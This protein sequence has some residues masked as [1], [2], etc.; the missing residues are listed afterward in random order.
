MSNL[1]ELIDSAELIITDEGRVYH[2]DLLPEELADTIL[3]VG[4]PARVDL[5]AEY[6]DNVE[7]RRSHREFCTITGSYRNQRL[8]VI[9][10]GIGTDN[11][12]IVVNEL[13][14]LVNIDFATRQRR[15]KTRSLQLIRMGTCGAL[16]KQVQ[17][18]SLIFSDW[19]LGL[20][21]LIY[22]YADYARVLD[23][24]L[25]AKLLSS[26]EWQIPQI[27]P[28]LVQCSADLRA[29]FSS[30]KFLHGLTLT[31]PGFYG[32]QVRELRLASRLKSFE[33]RDFCHNLS[34]FPPILNFE[35]EISALYAL[36]GLLEHKAGAVCVAVA[37]RYAGTFVKN[38]ELAVR[39][40][41]ESVLTNLVAED[42]K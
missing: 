34:E 28:Y 17:A 35:M 40:L 24:E 26:L 32:P 36:A 33:Q 4:D 25:N 23:S 5:V 15:E 22:Y 31:A 38:S 11:I 9:S 21:N 10:T 42:R 13:D 6:W 1:L 7:F 39:N 27:S 19:A 37:N 29:V 41:I 8:S 2:L 30:G 12:D 16:N 3:L 20:D 14:A 18:G